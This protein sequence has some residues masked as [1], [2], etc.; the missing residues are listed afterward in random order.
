L[1]YAYREA[2]AKMFVGSD[3]YKFEEDAEIGEDSGKRQRY[4]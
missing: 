3:A 1:C 4:F 2:A